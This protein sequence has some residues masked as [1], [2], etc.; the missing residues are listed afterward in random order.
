MALEWRPAERCGD[1]AGVGQADDVERG[2]SGCRAQ[3]Q[4]LCKRRVAEQGGNAGSGST[5]R[6]QSAFA[7]MG[8]IDSPGRS[9]LSRIFILR[10]HL[11]VRR[12]ECDEQ[13]SI[14]SEV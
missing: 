9:R 5:L 12:P 13:P 3:P 6:T 14:L 11:K 10:N 4:S 2:A 7:Q 1:D 8:H